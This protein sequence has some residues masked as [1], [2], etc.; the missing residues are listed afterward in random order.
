MLTNVLDLLVKTALNVQIFP[1]VTCAVVKEVLQG[2]TAT[3]VSQ[4]A[5]FSIPTPFYN[6]T[7]YERFA[8]SLRGFYLINFEFVNVFY[9]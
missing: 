5:L 9:L 8:V 7:I 1:G 6:L 4:L 3:Q 2:R